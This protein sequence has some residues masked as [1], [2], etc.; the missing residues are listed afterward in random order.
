M[1]DQRL[2]H[3]ERSSQTGL[4]P[5]IET[6]KP[7]ALLS[8]T[9]IPH[10]PSPQLLKQPRETPPVK[11]LPL[12]QHTPDFFHQRRANHLHSLLPWSFFDVYNLPEEDALSKTF[13]TRL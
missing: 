12:M 10:P 4:S 9:P 7:L 2:S 5:L 3:T 11:Y 1:A 8:A 6:S 13:I